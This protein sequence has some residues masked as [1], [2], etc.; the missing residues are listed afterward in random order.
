[1]RAIVI[2]EP[3]GPEVLQ[4]R[5]L[6]DPVPAEGEVLI[7]VKA[8]GVNHAETL[9]RK[10]EWPEAARSAASRPSAP[11]R[12]T[13]PARS[14]GNQRGHD[15]GRAG[16]HAQ[17]Q[18][19]RVLAAPATNVAT[20]DTSLSWTDLAAIPES[21]ATAWSVL[22]GNLELQPGES[23]ARAGCDLGA[24]AGRGE[25]RGRPGRRRDRHDRREDRAGC[26][27]RWPRTRC[28]STRGD[29]GRGPPVSRMASTGSRPGRQQRAARLA[30]GRCG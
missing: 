23:A 28:S 25:H 15:H 24:R 21:Y 20:I 19:R 26:R 29:R 18:L 10:G 7:R 22:H 16:T 6:P 12:T 13:P 4:I 3:G 8:F 17:W 27:A 11:S 30:E 1:M 5:E 14:P 9:M 2:T